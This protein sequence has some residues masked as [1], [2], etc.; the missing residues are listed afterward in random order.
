MAPAAP[1]ARYA[2]DVIVGTEGAPPR[3]W[4]LE[5]RGSHFAKLSLRNNLPAGAYSL[6]QAIFVS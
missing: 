5:P 2:G 1:L 4:I 6:E 3:F